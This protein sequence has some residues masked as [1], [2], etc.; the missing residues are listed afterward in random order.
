MLC[1]LVCGG[2]VC[3]SDYVFFIIKFMLLCCFLIGGDILDDLSLDD[4]GKND[5]L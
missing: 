2:Y 1:C 3:S 5:E 4:L